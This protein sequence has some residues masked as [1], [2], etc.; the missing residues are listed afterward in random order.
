M[1]KNQQKIKFSGSGALNKNGEGESA[2]KTVVT[3]A[4]TMLMHN[5]FRCTEEKMSTYLWKMAMD[6][7]VCIYNWISDMQDGL[8]TI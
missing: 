5:E 7:A 3:M 8:T 4:R 1:L 6:H 2:I